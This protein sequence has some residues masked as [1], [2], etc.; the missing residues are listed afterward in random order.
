MSVGE[1]Q[2]VEFRMLQEQARSTSC[3]HV[4]ESGEFL[5]KLLLKNTQTFSFLL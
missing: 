3:D 1:K 5:N 2:L 4:M